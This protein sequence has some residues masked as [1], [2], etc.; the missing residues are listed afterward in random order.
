MSESDLTELTPSQQKSLSQ[1]DA[2][3]DEYEQKV[4]AGEMAWLPAKLALAKAAH[5]NSYEIPTEMVNRLKRAE[6]HFK[7]DRDNAL[8]SKVHMDDRLFTRLVDPKSPELTPL[9]PADI[10]KKDDGQNPF[11]FLEI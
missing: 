9:P 3:I 7:R 8:L 1:L 6:K 5:L 11:D 4:S 2:L 10:V